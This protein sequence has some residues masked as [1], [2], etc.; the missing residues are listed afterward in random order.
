M[1]NYFRFCR[2]IKEYYART[3]GEGS[4]ENFGAFIVSTTVLSLNII[5]LIITIGFVFQNV[6]LPKNSILASAV[7]FLSIALVNYLVT[8]K[9][10]RYLEYTAGEKAINGISVL[11]YI[12][13]SILLI[14]IV[15]VINRECFL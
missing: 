2:Y 13:S 15:I 14:A 1:R 5:T 12:L 8:F 7:I 4:G 10:N 6:V 11:F 3:E 9:N